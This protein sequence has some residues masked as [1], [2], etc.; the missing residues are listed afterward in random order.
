MQ[1]LAEPNPKLQRIPEYLTGGIMVPFAIVLAVLMNS[2]VP[3]SAPKVERA[4]QGNKKPKEKPVVEFAGGAPHAEVMPNGAWKI[5]S[6]VH[7][8]VPLGWEFEELRV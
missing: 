2:P 4:V 6:T 1:S 7:Y 8:N 5:V 3:G